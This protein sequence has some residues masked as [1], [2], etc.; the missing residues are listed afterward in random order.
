MLT[1][2]LY[3][4]LKLAGPCNLCELTFHSHPLPCPCISS[5]CFSKPVNAYKSGLYQL[6]NDPFHKVWCRIPKGPWPSH[7]K[8]MPNAV[9]AKGIR[10]ENW[11][12]MCSRAWIDSLCSVTFSLKSSQLYAR[13]SLGITDYLSLWNPVTV[14]E[15][16]HLIIL[17]CCHTVKRSVK[18]Q[19]GHGQ[20]FL[21]VA[22]TEGVPRKMFLIAC[23][24]LYWKVHRLCCCH[25]HQHCHPW[26]KSGLCFFDLPA[27][28]E[29]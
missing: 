29:S 6:N 1:G 18:T 22:Q 28:T 17:G 27:G 13:A 8:Q 21:L 2:A 20:P 26:L 24:C 15:L 11:L 16:S 4:T 10:K 19:P 12:V 3:A 14:N 9:S 25:Q 5:W 7:Y 23:C